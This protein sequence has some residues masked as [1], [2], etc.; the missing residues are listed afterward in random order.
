MFYL[1]S[2]LGLCVSG[3][4]LVACSSQNIDEANSGAPDAVVETAP[5]EAGV[6]NIYSSR[7]YDTDLALYTDFTEQTGIEVN[8]IEADANALIERLESEGELSPADL[9]ITVDAG[10]LWRADQAGLLAPASSDVLETRIPQNL[11]HPE[12]H[13]FG[14]SKRARVIIYNK[15]AITPEGL[16]TYSNLADPKYSGQVCIRSSSNIYNLSLMA[17]IIE[18]EGAQAAER[19]ARGVVANFARDPQSNDTG[20]IEAVASGECKLAIVNTYYL[21]RLV[22]SDDPQRKEIYDAI[23]I[24]F[25]NQDS[26]GTHVN[27][28]GAGVTAHSPNRANA[29]MFLEYLT[30]P[31]AQSYFA[32]GNN[33]YPITAGTPVGA[34]A[35]A[36]GSFKEDTINVAS[37]GINQRDAAAAYDRAGWK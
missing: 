16:D 18:R 29:V 7:H 26:T 23:G 3:L 25:P 27:I 1:K 31:S 37:F 19:W 22:A 20:Q 8:R 17:S 28:S 11:R 35:Q 5:R 13:W 32:N 9:L 15:E 2:I 24:V 12:G 30:S 33:E 4:A 21:A 36:L 10:V 14:L 6:V 34:A